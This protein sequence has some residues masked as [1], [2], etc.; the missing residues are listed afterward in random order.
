M[1]IRYGDSPQLSQ[2]SILCNTG[3]GK[4]LSNIEINAKRDLP[5]IDCFKATD[6]PALIV[7]GGSSLA[8]TL[9]SIRV[10]QQHGSRVFALNNT[11]KYLTENGIHPDVQIVLDPRPL[12]GDFI[13]QRWAGE[14]LLS[15]QCD[16]SLFEKCE[17]IGYPVRIWHPY[18]EGAEKVIPEENPL[19]I[20][21]GLTVGLSG[22]CLVYT[23]GHRSIHLFGFDSCHGEDGSHAYP[24]PM[25]DSDELMRVC[26]KNRAF[27]CS[28]TMAAQANEFE[29]VVT[30]LTDRE[31]EIHVHGDG[32]IPHI[33]QEMMREVKVLTA[34]YDLS[35][36]PPTYEFISFLSEAEKSRI[37][38]GFDQIDVVFQP[39]PMF[40]FRDDQLPPSIED[41]E[42]MLSRIC[43]SACRLLPSVRNVTVLKDRQEING[44]VFPEGYSEKTPVSQYGPKY[45]KN[46]IPC[47]TATSYAKRLVASR[48]KR[49]FI[50]IT[51]REA[52]Y[53]PERNSQLRE[54]MKVAR[55][56]RCEGIEVIFIPD[57]NGTPIHEFHCFLEAAWDIDLRLA[58]Y[59]KALMN[60]TVSHGPATLLYTSHAT[61]RVFN[62][63]VSTCQSS[64]QA[65]L[66]AHGIERDTQ[67]PGNGKLI[68]EADTYDVI[69][70]EVNDFIYPSFNDEREATC[71]QAM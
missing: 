62:P 8:S 61:Y 42:A 65:F 34:V 68:W 67:F 33:A 36:S 27:L 60:L 50:T 15:S 64:S 13:T 32:L 17:E 35:V 10:M 9:E 21:G 57:T 52:D 40:G 53:W 38:Q 16:P 3:D 56:I 7:G 66:T 18:I 70:R 19:M 44:T 41:R 22:M 5:H 11:A 2:L 47:L 6:Q 46:S 12:T 1:L 4:L 20:G 30:Q 29:K 24:Q 51:I 23:L 31:C 54:W 39:G 25:N 58:A 71:L 14:V 55:W 63:V 49:P 43:V 48:F 59:E 45:Q 26:V 69:K 37:E 28:T